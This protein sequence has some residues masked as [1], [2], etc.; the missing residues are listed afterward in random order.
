MIAEQLRLQRVQQRAQQLAQ[1]AEALSTNEVSAE[2]LAALPP[3]IQ[4]EVILI[5]S[6]CSYLYNYAL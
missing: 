1:Q 5:T 2:F 4:E 6:H 3:N